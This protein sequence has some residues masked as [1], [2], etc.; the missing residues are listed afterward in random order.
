MYWILAHFFEIFSCFQFQVRNKGQS[1]PDQAKG[2]K[3]LRLLLLDITV[4]IVF[5]DIT[6]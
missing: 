1:S 4:L 3:A 2:S 6:C 5:L